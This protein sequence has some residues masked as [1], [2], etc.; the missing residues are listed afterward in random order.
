[1]LSTFSEAYDQPVMAGLQRELA[2]LQIRGE[3]VR[4]QRIQLDSQASETQTLRQVKQALPRQPWDLVITTS[5]GPAQ[6]VRQLNPTTPVLFRSSPDP[7]TM[8]LV[9]SLRQP[10]TPTTGYFSE[11]PAEGKMVEALALAFPRLTGVAMLV[12]G[13]SSNPIPAACGANLPRPACR[14]G[15]VP[16]T[17]LPLALD[18]P[19]GYADLR[20]TTRRARLPL[21]FVRICQR[22]DLIRLGAWLSPGQGVL[23]P[24]SEGF[25]LDRIEVVSRLQ[26]LR[27]P[28]IYSANYMLRAGGLMAIKPTSEPTDAP[29]RGIEL[30]R[31][32]LEGADPARIP[33]QRSEGFEFII[34]LRAA[35]AMGLTPSKAALR[36][37]DRLLR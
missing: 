28:V 3:P 7:R 25:Y 6:K 23:V 26:T 5:L 15:L 12:D 2:P 37:A 30:A 4:I 19:A 29:P 22:E 13:R 14:P 11:L 32:I 17:E 18:N 27:H 9:R 33:I 21:H 34:N 8:C 35:R 16:D 31:R 20:L 1:M 36:S 24:V 10:G